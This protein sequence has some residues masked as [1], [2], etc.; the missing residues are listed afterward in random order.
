MTLEHL[1]LT[2]THTLPVTHEG[3]VHNGKVRSVYWLTADDSRRLIASRNY[4]VRMD[5]RL[6][7][8]VTSDRL[9]AFDVIWTGEDGLNGV[10]GKGASLNSASHH[11]F[12][13]LDTTGL[14]GHHVL[15]APH[16]LV[17]I[18]RRAKPI[19]VEAV[20]RQYITGSM[21]RD[22][23]KGSR[24]FCGLTLPDDLKK[25][26]RLLYLLLT[27]TTKGVLDIPGISK[28]DDAPMTRKQ[29]EDNYAALGFERIEDVKAFE[30]AQE[31]CYDTIAEKLYEIDQLLADT[32]FEMGYV[33]AEE[34]TGTE[35]ILMDEIATP[36]SS[37]YWD[38]EA[39]AHGNVVENSKE[40]FRQ[41][42]LRTLDKDVLLNPDRMPERR[43][44]AASYRVP[45]AEMMKVA[46]TYAAMTQKITGKP[47]PRIENAKAEITDALAGYG[48]V[49]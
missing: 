29:I 33:P 26:Q 17:W 35:M 3:Q 15:D 25:N 4:P 38:R 43:Q 20:A 34:G 44:L 48:L 42:L 28:K 46:E 10:P 23:E 22:Y 12:D 41:F 11:W 14:M 49:A 32:K 9:S 6:G 47:L 24:T 30:F 19:M 13:L 2:E 45:V 5:D 39:Y 36:D 40:G 1:A 27:P 7:V 8:M 31:V 21:W 18:V 16:P 37:R